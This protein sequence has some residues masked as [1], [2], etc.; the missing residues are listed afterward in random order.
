[1]AINF[2]DSPA[3]SNSSSW[4]QNLYIQ[5]CKNKWDTTATE[6]TGQSTVYANVDALPTSGSPG[7]QAAANVAFEWYRMV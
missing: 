6:V 4:W 7:A 3:R 5:Q 2:T 1:M